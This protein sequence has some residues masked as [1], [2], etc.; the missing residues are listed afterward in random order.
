[1]TRI[2]RRLANFLY[3]LA[4]RVD[5]RVSVS[6]WDM[7]QI[8]D[9]ARYPKNNYDV[10]TANYS[11]HM[12]P[13]SP[14]R[15]DFKNERW[16]YTALHLGDEGSAATIFLNAVTARKLLHVVREINALYDRFGD[17]RP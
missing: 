15:A 9:A 6:D 4:S 14:V 3:R 17:R 8:G 11:I 5:R 16:T 2:R 12:R 10:S 7:T 1:M 13:T